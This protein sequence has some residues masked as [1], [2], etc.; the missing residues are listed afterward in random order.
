MKIGTRITTTRACLA[1]FFDKGQHGTVIDGADDGS[2]LVRFDIDGRT[3]WVCV[4]EM[5]AIG[6]RRLPHWIG[7]ALSWLNLRRELLLT[8]AALGLMLAVG[9]RTA[10]IYAPNPQVPFLS[11]SSAV[12]G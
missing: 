12:R 2:Y 7:L 4:D 3:R 9:Y 5:R 1:G 8:V 10:Q 6:K 11:A